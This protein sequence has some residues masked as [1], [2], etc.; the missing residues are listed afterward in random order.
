MIN[1]KVTYFAVLREQAGKSSEEITVDAMTVCELYKH[2]VSLYNL[3]VD[4]QFIQYSIN[5][6]FVEADT[7]L[8][9]GDHI[10]F[11]P[12]VVGG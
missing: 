7:Q 2:L 10:V 6:E 12:P 1:I 9:D 5:S 11:I 8:H 3:K 4:S